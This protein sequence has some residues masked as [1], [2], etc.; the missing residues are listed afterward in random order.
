[1]IEMGGAGPASDV[2]SVGCVVCE[3]LTGYVLGLSQIPPPCLPHLFACTTRDVCNSASTRVV[4]SIAR[5]GN[6]YGV[7]EI[8]TN[9]SQGDCSARLLKVP[10]VRPNYSDP[11]PPYSTPVHRPTRD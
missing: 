5:T 6:I 3:L 8:L 1:V 11:N 10:C 9:T 7:L 4:C 2:W